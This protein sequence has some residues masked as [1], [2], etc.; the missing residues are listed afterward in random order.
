M[1]DPLINLASQVKLGPSYLLPRRGGGLGRTDGLGLGMMIEGV[2][3]DSGAIAAGSIVKAKTTT[4]DLAG[5]RLVVATADELDTPFG[6]VFETG[7]PADGVG[8]LIRAGVATVLTDGAVAIA[9]VLYVSDTAG[10]AT[11]APTSLDAQPVGVARTASA[12]GLASVVADVE[13]EP[14]GVASIQA[15]QPQPTPGTILVVFDAGEALIAALSELDLLIPFAC[16]ITSWHILG[17]PTSGNA[18]GSTVI[19]IWSDSYGNYPPTDADSITAAAPPTLTAAVKATDSTLTGWSRAITAGT[20][21]RFHIDSVATLK[22][23]TLALN[24]ERLL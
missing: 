17:A 15:V 19:D 2:M 13:V 4:Y 10:R 5:M 6:V 14:Y 12:G 9:D 1:P 20:I 21:L 22:R 8:R 11:A 23:L 3:T 18:S 24:Y 16:T 7:I